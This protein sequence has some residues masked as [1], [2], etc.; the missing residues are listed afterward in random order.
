MSEKK[1][2]LIFIDWFLPGFKA[3]GPIRSIA[4]IIEHLSKDFIFKIITTN[5]DYLEKTPY[6]NIESN[7]WTSFNKST[8]VYYF[9]KEKLTKNRL[10][11][12]VREADFD[13]AYINGIYSFYFSI[14]PLFILR[15]SKKKIIVAARGML[16]KHA[17]SSKNIKKTVFLKLSKLFKLYKNVCFQATDIN[18]ATEIKNILNNY[19]EIITIPNLPKKITYSENKKKEKEVGTIKLVSIARI[20]TEKNTLFALQMLNRQN[21]NYKGKIE[22][23]LFGSIYDEEYWQ[24]CQIQIQKTPGNISV[25]YKGSI[26]S[27]KVHKTFSEYHFSFMPSKGENF[28]HSILES[29]SAGCPVITSNQ[30]PWQNLEQKKVGWDISLRD[31]KKFQDVI[32]KCINM[33]QEEYDIISENAFNFAKDF[34]ENSQAITDTKKMFENE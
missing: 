19:K 32:Q 18:E 16:S 25:S 33:K 5:T 6:K 29:F 17:F 4:N 30:T 12:I 13:I 2:I 22:L 26:E 1:K 34:L 31:E 14:L 3:G 9:S 27:S 8:S 10:I 21:F 11:K 28:G 24:K 7:K 20:S 23:D 15:K